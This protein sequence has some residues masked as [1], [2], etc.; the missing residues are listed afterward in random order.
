MP[1]YQEKDKNGKILKTKDG[2]SWRYRC[3]YTDSYGNRRRKKG[4]HYL[5]KSEAE[6]AERIFLL[7][8][9]KNGLNLDDSNITFIEVYEEWLIYK[10]A[11]IKSTTYYS[12]KHRCDKHIKSFFKE[13]KLHSIKLNN[14]NLWKKELANSGLDTK[15]Q[16][17]NIGSLQEILN[18]AKDN[19]DFD[20]R[21][22]AQIQKYRVDTYEKKSKKSETN[23]FTYED[24]EK[25]INIVDDQYY[26]ILFN[27]LYFT[28]VRY[29]EMA[30]LSW[31]EIDLDK[32]KLYI[33]KSLSTKVDGSNYVITSPKTANSIRTVD[34]DDNLIKLLK[35]HKNNEKGIYNFNDDMFVFG[36][37]RYQA[38]T[39]LNK[40]LYKYI[41]SAKVKKIT[42]HGFR[43]SH[44]S[45]LIDLGCD[46]REVAARLG[47][48]VEQ[49]EKTY[50][51]M[52]PKKQSHTVSVLNNMKN[53][54]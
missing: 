45:L 35:T 39:T 32:G 6:E 13:F 43:H 8:A 44:A 48:T 18:Y 20:G 33:K 10:S 29:G 30:A 42:P 16:N 36:N 41:E 11:T 51:H 49:V 1:V 24:F 2:R 14:I 25:F 22:L 15:G 40:R 3:Y 28:G 31:K 34:L 38:L 47:D 52:F 46:S 17:R 23:F 27:F 12:T 5:K 19:Y 50:Y 26:Y 21:V 37:V 53:R 7:S 9:A 4:G 54:P